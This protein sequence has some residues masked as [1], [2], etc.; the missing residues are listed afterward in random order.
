MNFPCFGENWIGIFSTWLEM[1]ATQRPWGILNINT[2]SYVITINLLG[3]WYLAFDMHCAAFT[4]PNRTSLSH[5][6]DT[7]GTLHSRALSNFSPIGLKDRMRKSLHEKQ[8]SFSGLYLYLSPTWTRKTQICHFWEMLVLFWNC[9]LL[10]YS[11]TVHRSWD[12]NK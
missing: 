3:T 6:I 10:D 2:K 7:A 5:W 1:L 9:I 8:W 12:T 4:E 11:L